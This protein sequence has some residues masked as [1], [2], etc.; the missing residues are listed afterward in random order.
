MWVVRLFSA[1]GNKD[2][3]TQEAQNINSVD[4]GLKDERIE[5]LKKNGF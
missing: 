5:F 2:K 1:L 3:Y 4:S